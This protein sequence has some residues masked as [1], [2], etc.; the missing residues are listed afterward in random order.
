LIAPYEIAVAPYEI[1]VC[2]GWRSCS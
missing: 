1:A 2:I